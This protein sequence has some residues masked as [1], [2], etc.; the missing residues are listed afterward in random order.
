[1][2]SYQLLAISPS[3]VLK[4]FEQKFI[5]M[6]TFVQDFVSFVKESFF[7][8]VENVVLLPKTQ[9]TFFYY[10]FDR[11]YSFELWTILFDS[12]PVSP[13]A[14]RYMMTVLTSTCTFHAEMMYSD[15]SI[16]L[17][18]GVRWDQGKTV[19][20]QSL[21]L[22]LLGTQL[23]PASSFRWG[24]S[25][26]GFHSCKIFHLELPG[27]YFSGGSSCYGMQYGRPYL[28]LSDKVNVVKTSH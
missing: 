10:Q 13:A 5:T 2:K 18:R 19:L 6:S 25:F 17:W 16:S 23:L 22:H 11:G 24:D 26:L 8:T 4:V 21:V 7:I 9:I 14:S 1:M 3:S 12:F 27:P 28:A 20:P 15:H